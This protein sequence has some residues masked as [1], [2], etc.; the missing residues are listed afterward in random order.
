MSDPKTWPRLAEAIQQTFS[1]P[2]SFEAAVAR[3][4]AHGGWS[5]STPATPP[6]DPPPSSDPPAPP[7]FDAGAFEGA[8]H[9]RFG[10]WPSVAEHDDERR[11]IERGEPSM[12]AEYTPAFPSAGRTINPP[13]P[14]PRPR[15]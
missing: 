5:W 12:L 9:R 4:G 11:R 7:R 2:E 14:R 6:S 10:R 1:A 13:G 8:Y 3:R 15:R